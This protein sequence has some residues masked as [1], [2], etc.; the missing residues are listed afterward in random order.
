MSTGNSQTEDVKI[1]IR[2]YSTGVKHNGR[3]VLE[4]PIKTNTFL[5]SPDSPLS[6]L[7]WAVI[8]ELIGMT[9]YSNTEASATDVDRLIKF[10]TELKNKEMNISSS[11]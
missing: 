6:S 10:L 7:G 3:T 5:G 8:Q 2:L 4:V 11:K 9:R 1:F